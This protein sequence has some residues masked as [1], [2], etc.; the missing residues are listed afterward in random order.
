MNEPIADIL[1]RKY[2]IAF[3]VVAVLVLSNEVLVQPSMM[4]LTTDAPL[5]NV[6]GRQRMLSQRLA[7]ATLA[8]DG[9]RGEQAKAYLEE[10]RAVLGLWSDS[11]E[12]LVQ[13]GARTSWAGPNTEAVR[14]GLLGLE[15]HF[16]KMRDAARGVIRA[17]EGDRPDAATVREGLAIILDNEAEY[18]RRMDRVVRLYESEARGRIDNLR[19]ITWG[20]TGLRRKSGPRWS[21][22]WPRRCGRDGSSHKCGGL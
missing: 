22:C 12:Q 18:L 13:G 1:D 19:R 11:H 20:V 2:R 21:D 3:T 15:P 6:A 8:F 14:E 9:A 17:R 16:V 7:K 5:I 4:R 10:M